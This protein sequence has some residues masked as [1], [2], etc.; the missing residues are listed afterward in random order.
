[1]KRVVGV[2]VALMLVGAA[3]GGDDDAVAASDSPLVA[4]LADEISSNED[5]D[6]P[7]SNREEAECWAGR[8]VGGIGE[9]R[10]T[11]LGVTAEDVGEIGDYNFTED[12]IDV[13]VDSM[14]KCIDLKAA[15]AETFTEDFGA[16]GAECVAD[17]LDGDLLRD[18]MAAG[19][20][21]SEPP[22]EF[23]QEFLDIAAKCDLP[24]N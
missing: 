16:E 20:T 10:L 17:E 11:E 9:G 19:I 18:L 3:C 4:A 1:M 8:I 14:D 23:F 13:I 22:D 15:L 12:E 7:F 2:M 5:G 21:D 6:S 24:L